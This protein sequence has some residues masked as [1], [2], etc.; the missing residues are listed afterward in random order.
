MKFVVQRASDWS[1]EKT[2]VEINSLEELLAFQ[3]E[4]K[5]S[6]VISQ[7]VSGSPRILIYDDY[8]E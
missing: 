2:E 4:V 7:V 5:H 6:I 8:L 3:N 1:C